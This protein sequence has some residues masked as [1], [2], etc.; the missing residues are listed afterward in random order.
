MGE[1]VNEAQCLCRCV[2]VQGA[3]V[4]AEVQQGASGGGDALSRPAEEVELSER[5]GLLR[6]HVLKVEAPHQEV[7]APDVLGHQVHLDGHQ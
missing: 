6:L 3:G 4:P 1:R 2:G 5:P 7:I